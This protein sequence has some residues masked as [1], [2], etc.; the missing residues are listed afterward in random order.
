MI[1]ATLMFLGALGAT[2]CSSL[3]VTSPRLTG[4]WA[5]TDV[6]LGGLVIP[7]VNF[8]GAK[9]QLTKTTYEFGNDKATYAVPSTIPPA[10]IDIRGTA[11]PIAGRT[12]QAI[13]QVTGDE[14][15]ICYQLGAG[16]RPV[17]FTPPKGSQVL[18]VHYR[19]VK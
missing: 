7:V 8:A 5:P 1:R 6:E 16:E 17:S 11:G 13:Y 3:P 14:L 18:L 9:L 19:R 12:I 2:A 10:K 4:R 15:T